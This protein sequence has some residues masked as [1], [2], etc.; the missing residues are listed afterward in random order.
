MNF[1]GV[2]NIE[3]QLLT[4]LVDGSNVTELDASAVLRYST[5][6]LYGK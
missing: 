3:G 5:Q 4:D 1:E 6:T 2:V